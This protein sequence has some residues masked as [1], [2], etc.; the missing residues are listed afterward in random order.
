MENRS[1]DRGGIWVFTQS[2]LFLVYAVIPR[3]LPLFLPAPV[4]VTG[5]ALLAFGAFLLI[6]SAF[7][8]GRNLTPFPKPKRS[9][10][11]IT[12]GIYR[13]VRHPMYS[14]LFFLLCG[15]ALWDAH[16]GRLGVALALAVFFDR[17]ARTEERRLGEAYPEYAGYSRRTKKFIPWI[18]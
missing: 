2:V 18:Y 3:L 8:L 1:G 15:Y 7:N 4:R 9:G 17:K 10:T 13:F 12:H 6:P 16:A 11:L 5:L 14:G